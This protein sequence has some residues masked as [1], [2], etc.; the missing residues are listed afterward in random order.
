MLPAGQA[1]RTAD[2]RPFL[3]PVCGGRGYMPAGFYGVT[4]GS[5]T[6]GEFCRSCTGQGIVWGLVHALRGADRCS[7]TV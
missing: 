3:C 4:R 5:S 1:T 6:A 7:T 2:Q